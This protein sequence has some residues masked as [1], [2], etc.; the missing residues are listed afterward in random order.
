MFDRIGLEMWKVRNQKHSKT[1]A[2]NFKKR[3]FQTIYNSKN[4]PTR[5]NLELPLD[6]KH[7]GQKCGQGIDGSPERLPAFHS[8]SR[9]TPSS[10]EPTAFNRIRFIHSKFHRPLS[11]WV[12]FHLLPQH[13]LLCKFSYSA[14]KDF[15][16]L[17]EVDTNSPTFQSSFHCYPSRTDRQ[18]RC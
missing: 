18:Q 13:I 6:A 3:T 2:F 14:K 5:S 9:I 1:L 16:Q 10:L 11:F 12:F 17:G 15:F 7:C 4:P 8:S